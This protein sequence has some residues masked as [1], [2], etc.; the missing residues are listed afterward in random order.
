M[1]LVVEEVSEACSCEDVFLLSLLP[2]FSPFPLRPFSSPV[3][4]PMSLSLPSSSFLSFLPLSFHL[5]T[6]TQINMISL[7]ITHTHT[8][9]HT[10]PT[11]L[12]VKNHS[13]R[14]GCCS[15]GAHD[16]KLSQYC[17]LIVLE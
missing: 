9:A 13:D 5:H 11:S 14:D 8:Y 10:T 16:L 17:K 2:L 6:H 4:S 15:L 3:S 1:V 12:I 7:T